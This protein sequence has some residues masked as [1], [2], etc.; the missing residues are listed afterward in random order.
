M[1]NSNYNLIYNNINFFTNN[2]EKNLVGYKNSYN[3]KNSESFFYNMLI[4]REKDKSFTNKFNSTI[5]ALPYFKSN[6][7]IPELNNQSVNDF[8]VNNNLASSES[9][10]NTLK[11]SKAYLIHLA[12]D[13]FNREKIVYEAICDKSV[14]SEIDRVNQ[15]LN[16][17]KETGELV[18]LE[19][20]YKDYIK[21]L[22]NFTA[23]YQKAFQNEKD[24]IAEL[25]SVMISFSNT[26]IF[27]GQ[28]N[29]FDKSVYKLLSTI[30]EDK[31]IDTTV[32]YI[33]SMLYGY[34]IGSTS[35][36]KIPKMNLS[37][38]FFIKQKE[39]VT[40][41]S[42]LTEGNND[43][44]FNINMDKLTIEESNI[45]DK[46]SKI[47]T[48]KVDAER[49]KVLKYL[50]NN[51]TFSKKPEDNYNGPIGS[52]YKILFDEK[53]GIISKYCN[54]KGFLYTIF[55][56]MSIYQTQKLTQSIRELLDI[57][58]NKFN[59]NMGSIKIVKENND[60]YIIKYDNENIETLFLKFKTDEDTLI[61][62]VLK[63]TSTSL[64]NDQDKIIQDYQNSLTQFNDSIKEISQLIKGLNKLFIEAEVLYKNL[65]SF[66][67]TKDSAQA[68]YKELFEIREENTAGTCV[69][70]GKIPK[71]Q[72]KS[73][74][75]AMEM[76]FKSETF[77][78]ALKNDIV[79]NITKINNN[80]TK[81]LEKL[82]IRK[83][84]EAFLI[85]DI[86]NQINS[87]VEP[88][89]KMPRFQY[90]KINKHL[91]EKSY[92]VN[93]IKLYDMLPKKKTKSKEGTQK[94][95]L[96]W[97]QIFHQSSWNDF[98]NNISNSI[99]FK[100][101]KQW[102][103]EAFKLT[104][105]EYMKL[106]VKKESILETNKTWNDILT[107][108]LR[109]MCSDYN[110][111]GNIY[112]Q[113]RN[114]SSSSQTAKGIFGEI[115]SQIVGYLIGKKIIEQKVDKNY[116][117]YVRNTGAV[118]DS[119]ALEQA[120]ADTVLI[121]TGEG[122]KS[123]IGIQAKNYSMSQKHNAT[124]GHKVEQYSKNYRLDQLS[125]TLDKYLFGMDWQLMKFI[126]A[127]S[128]GL[129]NSVNQ[130]CIGQLQSIMQLYS[131]SFSRMLQK[132]SLN[133][134]IKIRDKKGNEQIIP[135]GVV[136][137]MTKI[138]TRGQKQ[139][140]NMNNSSSIDIINNFAFVGTD[141]IVSSTAI[142]FRDLMVIQEMTKGLDKSKLL[143]SAS[144]YYG[145]SLMTSAP[146]KFLSKSKDDLQYVND[147]IGSDVKIHT[148]NY[149]NYEDV[150]TNS[151]LAANL[152]AF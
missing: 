36:G 6:T 11:S 29:Y 141:L 100:D 152:L 22:R 54:S 149:W 77:T 64:K 90:D 122:K 52:I 72:I 108:S 9:D 130:N 113:L 3:I 16:S 82:S 48:K 78:D 68:I 43:N 40:N 98:K 119:I 10:I 92:N 35:F 63:I 5:A 21:I 4:Q 75:N 28:P 127:N 61:K 104:I 85:Q 146:N 133:S 110:T 14:Q 73:M 95:T 83:K 67:K 1:S 126:I 120:A 39:K 106:V 94:I 140:E 30:E 19:S 132:Q 42:S 105:N 150:Y 87:S 129:E 103:V 60:L 26:G 69:L 112:D 31:N 13:S 53:D 138:I 109:H 135:Q 80:A 20:I 24:E 58:I 7:K 44:I 17:T 79:K 115:Y 89:K 118:K 86:L 8:I 18:S 142:A 88:I 41:F 116:K 128:G 65:I 101:F 111:I 81:N 59:N 107:N 84:I 33:S 99:D 97:S 96:S 15:F 117:I 121:I 47:D 46:D 102:A 139:I 32:K 136:K 137:D 91:L 62:N 27:R 66:K 71:N 50:T 51:K 144:I 148:E 49:Q 114:P 25:L 134:I 143:M 74:Q 57:N 76:I 56:D 124:Q 151:N 145:D 55:E 45:K 12:K 23:K 70:S 2:S 34:V 123:I 38:K 125:S 131:A 147:A 37:S 93:N